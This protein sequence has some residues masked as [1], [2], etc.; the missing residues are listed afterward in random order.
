MLTG[1][2]VLC[3]FPDQGRLEHALVGKAAREGIADAGAA[4]T[5]ARLVDVCGGP[6]DLKRRL[7]APRTP[8][9]VLWA[10]ARAAAQGPFGAFAREPGFAKSALE[11]FYELKAG[12]FSAS[13]FK[14]A[15][16]ALPGGRR[17]RA[18]FLA[19]LFGAYE[20]RMG[21]A[22]LADREDALAEATERLAAQGLPA[23]IRGFA[24]IRLVQLH[25]FT[26]LRLSFVLALSRACEREGVH[27]HMQ[28]PGSGSPVVDAAVD[29]VFATF[30]RSAQ[31]LAYTELSKGDG[32]E[33]PGPLAT[34]GARL[35]AA[36]DAPPFEPAGFSLQILSARRPR[37]EARVLARWAASRVRAG[38][39]PAEVAIC[40]REPG[41][42]LSWIQE[43]L[44]ELGVP[45]EVRR[46]L[47][48]V[49]A[50]RVRAALGLA[51]L[52]DEGFPAAAVA[53]VLQ[54]GFLPRVSTGAPEGV[55]NLLAR[56]AIRDDRIGAEG[57]VGAYGARLARFADRAERWDSE[58]AADARALEL[59]RRRLWELCESIPMEGK[60]EILFERWWAAVL[61]SGLADEVAGEPEDPP[62]FESS[63]RRLVARR[64]WEDR[65]AL[66]TLR[67]S[68]EELGAAIDEA[69]AKGEVVSRRSFHRWLADALAD[70]NL[71]PQGSRTGG[72][73]L[74]DVREIAGLRL[75][76]LAIGGVN[77]G[78]FPGA[79]R[80]APLFSEEDRFAVNR[81]ARR[82]VFRLSTG[83]ADGR[84]PYRLAEDRLLFHAALSSARSAAV[85]AYAK[86]DRSG[87]PQHPSS[88]VAELERLS[89]VKAVG[90]LDAFLPAREQVA[91]E[92]ELRRRVALEALALV[93]PEASK[94]EFGAPLGERFAGEAWL[95][96]AAAVR[97]IERERADYF[98]D[99]RRQPG[100]FTGGLGGDRAATRRLLES[101]FSFDRGHPLSAST[102]GR[103][104]NCA[105]QGFLDR[106]LQLGED[107]SEG[108][109]ADGRVKGILYHKAFELLVRELSQ[110]GYFEGPTAPIPDEL[111]EHAVGRASHEVTRRAHVGHPALWA[112]AEMEL[113]LRARRLLADRDL[114]LPFEGLRPKE[115]ELVFGR[116]QA[117]D[118]WRD[119]VLPLEEG[120]LFLE[121]RIDRLD[122][123]A[124]GIGVID[125]KSGRIDKDLL[126]TDF[127]LAFYLY[128]VRQVRP[129]ERLHGAWVSIGSGQVEPFRPAVNAEELERFLATDPETR[130]ELRQSGG[131]NLANALQDLVARLRT[132][133]FAIRPEDCQGCHYLGVCRIREG[134]AKEGEGA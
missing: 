86:E 97:K 8:H 120:A 129:S 35:F 46:G 54:G 18:H 53:A 63:S 7:A 31:D 77:D 49:Q 4:F 115:F 67:D 124:N 52:P 74:L 82:D 3:V 17:E 94:K 112:L 29:P 107:E 113:T 50:P 40:F 9:L 96:E 21:R 79:S 119:V 64:Q 65:V 37:D 92:D 69:G 93:C 80:P 68:V 36:G 23:K 27:F 99:A 33:E 11:L 102:A 89:G 105:F 88:F 83:E 2:R 90:A 47:P 28:I 43:E 134:S 87:R 111:V 110:R 66:A 91:T 38:V 57:S 62:A 85:V 133:Q 10:C 15:A 12:R 131:D 30:E 128:A 59:C 114:A 127:Q 14:A 61:A 60:L 118:G 126:Q 73:K 51:V 125:Y 13:D 76:S 100:A 5:F 6:H 132:G 71:V 26:P 75:D 121:G 32:P 72:V 98:S 41:E 25:D 78:R 55:L 58:R 95:A 109:E 106:V 39:S 22:G 56:A 20:A 101:C 34:L 44:A 81:H 45:L 123:G 117:K 130:K 19:D 108:E 42:E 104:R 116:D 84:A 103:Y 122:E 70:R 1:S 24:G 48:L 16:N